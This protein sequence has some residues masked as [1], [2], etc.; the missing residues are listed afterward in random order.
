MNDHSFTRKIEIIKLIVSV[1]ISLSVAS[2]AY[3]VQHSVVEQ[4][5]HRTLLSNISAKTY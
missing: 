5:A 4:Q 2:I 1:I 3:V